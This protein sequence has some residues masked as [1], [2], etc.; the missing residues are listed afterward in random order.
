L[1]AVDNQAPFTY[2]WNNVMGGGYF[3]TASAID[4]AGHVGTA[5][6]V[7]ISVSGPTATPLPKID[8]T[9]LKPSYRLDE[10]IS[11]PYNA[12]GVSFTWEFTSLA[13]AGLESSLS[14]AASLTQSPQF[15]PQYYQNLREG[16]YRL[17]VTASRAV[18]GVQPESATANV[19]L[20]P[21]LAGNS[22]AGLKV[23]PNPWRSDVHTGKNISFGG[24]SGEITVKIFTTSG[25]LVREVSGNNV[26]TWDVKNKSGDRVASGIY[27]Y[28]IEDAQGSERKGKLAIIR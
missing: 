9:K 1:L 21:I 22:L 14:A 20:T 8:L 23:F 12:T 25:H 10:T 6:A 4:N 11:F 28:H 26:A 15:V 19:T 27:L 13:A 24:V 3:F 5:T 7:S 18:P 17:K 2:T 16:L